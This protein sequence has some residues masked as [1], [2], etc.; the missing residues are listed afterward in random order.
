MLFGLLA[1]LTAAI[2]MIVILGGVF[3]IIINKNING[4]ADRYRREI[5]SIPLLKMALPALADPE[6]PKYLS[7]KELR[8]KYQELR[9]MRDGL[10]EKIKEIE[11]ENTELQ[12]YKDE[13]EKILA[14]NEQVKND[15]EEQRLKIE[16]E[17]KKVGDEKRKIDELIVKNDKTGFKEYFQ[18]VNEET[19]KELYAQIIKEQKADENSKKF[20][21]IYENMDPADAARILE[22]IGN[23]KLEI[24]VDVFKNM[25]KEASSEILAAMSTGFASKVSEE[26]KELYEAEIK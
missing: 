4:L 6:D 3:Y 17:L 13:Y 12:K 18:N 1:F 7:E 5:Q 24:V 21:Q 23:S 2:I 14:E 19:A 8:I 20:A 25:K 22:E 16:Q 26:L 9:V 11:E 15:V 10:L